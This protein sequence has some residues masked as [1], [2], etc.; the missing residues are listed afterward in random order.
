VRPGD[1]ALRLGTPIAQIVV[2]PF[3]MS[4]RSPGF[5]EL[6]RLRTGTTEAFL[7]LAEL[8]VGSG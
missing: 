1:L 6:G 3:D 7:D 2:V 5:R 8:V 4:L